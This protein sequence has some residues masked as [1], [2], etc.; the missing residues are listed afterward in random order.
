M[1]LGKVIEKPILTERSVGMTS[2]GRYTFRVNKKATKG[3]ISDAVTKMFN[4]EVKGVR[5]SIVPGKR[6]RVAKRANIFTKRSTWKK[7]VVTIKEGQ[8]IDMFNKLLG[9]NK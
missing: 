6:K 4:V 7:A 9:E 2:E 5:T 8:K 3:S 1:R